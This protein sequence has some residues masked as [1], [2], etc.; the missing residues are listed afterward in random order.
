[1]SDPCENAPPEPQAA[2]P[3]DAAPLC[4]IVG[5][6]A[7]GK[8]ALALDVAERLDG[9]I[10]SMDSMLVYRGLDIGTAKP[11]AQE[12]A[13]VPHHLID[14]VE[15]HEIYDARRWLDDARARVSDVRS[16][17][18]LP[19]FVGGTGFYLAALL[20]GL[21]EAPDPD[22]AL[23]AALEQ[24]AESE[25]AEVLH[26]ELA[27]IDPTAAARIH[28]NDV[29][30][31]VRGLEVHGQTGRTLTD[32]QREWNDGPSE[33][34]NA[35]RIV[36]LHLETPVLDRRIAERTQVMLDAGWREEALSARE[37]GL[38]RSAAQALGYDHILAWADGDA[39]R[40]ETVA[41]IALRTRQFARRQRTWY[42]KFRVRWIEADAPDRLD[43]ALSVLRGESTESCI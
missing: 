6:T 43:R 35:A 18:R 40:A 8:T 28:A 5:P 39:S 30:R 29:R 32:W 11:S 22:L 1:M 31:V 2:E 14:Q 24:R 13:R 37:R 19:I 10:L 20:R 4:C 41:A 42:R 34:V 16:R 36:G 9:E 27:T 26:A 12:Q 15:P 25:G 23:R 38:S 7:T 3:L 33:R 17:G 21:F